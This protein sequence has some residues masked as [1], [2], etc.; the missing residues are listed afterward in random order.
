MPPSRSE[1]FKTIVHHK[2]AGF[3][4]TDATGAVHDD[5]LFA[6][7]LSAYLPPWAIAHRGNYHPA[8]QRIFKIPC[9]IFVM[10]AHINHYGIVIL[11]Q[12]IQ[13]LSICVPASLFMSNDGSL[14]PSATI[15]SRTIFST[16]NDLPSSSTAILGHHLFR[17]PIEVR[18]FLMPQNC[19]A[20]H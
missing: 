6:S 3:F 12:F 9:F 17:A 2:S 15:L 10:I 4:T 14:M 13:L 20:A 11:Q 5:I 19:F 1:T 7:V 8:L 18:I 16:R